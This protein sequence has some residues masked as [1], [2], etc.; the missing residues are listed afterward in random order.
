MPL[1]Q[2]TLE[3]LVELNLLEGRQFT[4]CPPVEIDPNKQYT[5]T[6]QTE[7]GDILISLFADKAPIA[8]NNFI[9][10]A[11]Q[12]WFDGVTFHRVLPGFMA[13]AGDPSGTGF[14][15]PGYAFVNEDTGIKF[16]RPGLVAMANAGP[17]TNGSQ[18]FITTGPAPH[19]DGGYTIFGEVL[20]GMEVVEKLTPRNPEQS[21]DL[22]PG[23]QILGV[24]ISEK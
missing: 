15:G 2:S 4:T 13:Q 10:L 23:D 20:Q 16:D 21:A 9:F 18:F 1:T 6:I 24:T 7:Q 5:A 11:R 8:A 22:P 19:L 17:D 12:G 3:G 14:G